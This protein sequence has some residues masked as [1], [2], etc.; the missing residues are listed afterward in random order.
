M[1][2]NP[3]VTAFIDR[4]PAWQDELRAMRKLAL[5]TGMAE[6]VKWGKPTYVLDGA[7]LIGLLP[8][9]DACVM[10]FFKGALLKDPKNMLEIPGEHSR[11]SRFL[12]VTALDQITSRESDIVALLDAAVAAEKAGEQI[13]FSQNREIPIPEELRAA[14]DADATL[15]K[16]FDDLTPGRKRG[17][18]IYFNGAKQSQTRANRVEKMTPRILEGLGFQD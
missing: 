5:A 3:K 10:N 4:Q 11:S 18:L 12:K 14:L 7:N 8:L 16:A 1:T 9:K 17:Y 13:D 2:S 6:E 15:R